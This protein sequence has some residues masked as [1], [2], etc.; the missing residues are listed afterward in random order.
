MANLTDPQVS[1][2]EMDAMLASGAAEPQL[3]AEFGDALYDELH[4]LARMAQEAKARRSAAAG[5]VFLLPGIMGSKLSVIDG[6]RS[7]EI[8]LSIRN[9]YKGRVT[10]LAYPSDTFRVTASG[11]FL[12]AYQRMRLRLIIKGHDVQF[13]P[14]DWREDIATTADDLWPAIEAVEKPVSLICHSM[15]GLVARAL[16]ARDGDRRLIRKVVTL[17]TPNLGSYSPVMTLRGLNDNVHLLARLDSTGIG[18]KALV[19]TLVNRFPG[20]LQMMPSPDARRDENWFDAGFWPKQDSLIPDA[21]IL[22]AA[23]KAQAELPPPDDRFTQI[24][25]LGMRTVHDVRIDKGELFYNHN[26]DGDGTV[27]RTLAEMD[28]ADRRFYIEGKHGQ[29]CNLR[30]AIDACDAVLNGRVPDLADDPD[31]FRTLTASVSAEPE[32]ALRSAARSGLP[33]TGD[34]DDP[35]FSEQALLE[36]FLSAEADIDKIEREALRPTTPTLPAPLAPH[37]DDGTYVYTRQK[38]ALRRINIDVM[39]ADILD[40]PADAYVLGIF[41]GVTTLGGAIGAV[42]YELDGMLSAQIADGQITGRKG[43]VTFIPIPR[44]HLRT[45]HVVVVGLGA[46]GPKDTITAAVRIA[47]RNMMRS[48]CISEVS[49]FAGVLLGAD[50]GPTPVEIFREL[51]G[52]IFEALED[53]DEDQSFSCIRL[54]EYNPDRYEEI[55]DGLNRTFA[56]FNMSDCEI[57]VQKKPA[58]LNRRRAGPAPH[59]KLPEIFT[60][61]AEVTEEDRDPVVTLQL[62]HVPGSGNREAQLATSQ[63]T[64]Q[65]SELDARTAPLSRAMTSEKLRGVAEDIEKLILSKAFREKMEAGQSFEYGLQVVCDTWASRIPWEVLHLGKAPVALRGG[66]NRWYLPATGGV[67]RAARRPVG[68]RNRGRPVNVLMVADPT[69]DLSGARKEARQIEATLAGRPGVRLD[70]REGGEATVAAVAAALGQD[71]VGRVYDIFHYAGHAFFDPADR[72]RSGLILAGEDTLHGTDIAD[73]A[74]VPGFVF[75]NACESLRVRKRGARDAGPPTA[76]DFAMRNTGLAEAFLLAGVRHIVGT[77]WPV[78]DDTAVNFSSVF[79]EQVQAQTIG[80][81]LTEARRIIHEVHDSSEW[82]NYIHYGAAND[83]I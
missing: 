5:H 22:A 23:G 12:F 72:A 2:E 66:L 75:L 37:T 11:V 16:A 44:H 80:A 78:N 55:A 27:P 39:N 21:A 29:L 10:E 63:M 59:P 47:G 62:H 41:E 71:D 73:L 50:S 9:L 31:A 46:F 64:F 4:V 45:S 6:A 68:A 1:A 81:A 57:V 38:K 34:P 15:G 8:W 60:V 14:F 40:V 43:E 79:Y 28:G 48:L 77:F 25:G 51:F 53:W 35:A 32:K 65:M 20:L 52:G 83:P 17:G 61:Q 18:P 13:L 67:R 69:R 26:D 58:P 76:Q 24:V 33:R 56:G 36:G 3:R 7:D 49:S 30:A 82:V 19:E 74:Q 42:D 54:C 70:T